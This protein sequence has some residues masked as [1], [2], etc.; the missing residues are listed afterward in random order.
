MIHNP[1][2]FTYNNNDNKNS[3]YKWT[4]FGSKI[5][6][7]GSLIEQKDH[8][9]LINAFNIISKKLMLNW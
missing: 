4:N 8:K 7:V 5:L 9:T 2:T 3:I 6:S 1:I